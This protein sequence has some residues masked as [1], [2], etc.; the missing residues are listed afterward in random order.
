[1]PPPKSTLGE[2]KRRQLANHQ[3]AKLP[4]PRGVGA[5]SVVPR[6]RLDPPTERFYIISK[7]IP[8]VGAISLSSKAD[9]TINNLTT[10]R[11]PTL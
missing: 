4:D 9:P 5:G 2:P 6:I 8:H 3:K 1:M 10:R 11:Y 7:H